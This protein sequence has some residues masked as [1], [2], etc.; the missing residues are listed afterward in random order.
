[1]MLAEAFRRHVIGLLL[2]QCTGGACH[3]PLPVDTVNGARCRDRIA[4]A[5]PT[6]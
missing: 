5:V 4:G 2:G 3:A 6:E 1:M